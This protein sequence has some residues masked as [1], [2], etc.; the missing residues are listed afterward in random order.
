MKSTVSRPRFSVSL[1]GLHALVGDDLR[2]VLEIAVRA[3]EVGI[4]CVTIP[5]HV[6]MGTRV[7]RYPYGTFPLPESFPWYEP[8]TLLSA[9][10]AVTTRIHL[11]PSV[12]IAPLRPPVLL[13]KIAATLDYLSQG[14]LELGVGTGWQVEE[15]EAIGVP[16]EK[17]SARLID[18]LR[19]CRVLWTGERS[20]FESPTVRYEEILSLPKPV[21][22]IPLFLGMKPTRT[23]RGWLAELGAGWVPMAVE[24]EQLAAD[25]EAIRAAYSDAGR[26]PAQLRVRAGLPVKL[27]G[28]RRPDLIGTLEGVEAAVSAG[29]TDIEIFLRAFAGSAAE[30]DDC[31][32]AIARS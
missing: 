15:Y 29:V 1:H 24:P 9:V 23:V 7:D 26:D 14:R 25:I 16:F 13:A 5:D 28:D 6:V 17:R 2:A 30:I 20:S 31:L 10:A 21:G 8:M 4:D 32:N 19:A 11:A 22:D 18:G 3:D 12:L 27:G